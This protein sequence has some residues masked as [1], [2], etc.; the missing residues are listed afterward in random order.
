MF[1]SPSKKETEAIFHFLFTSLSSQQSKEE[2]KFA[3]WPTFDLMNK[4]LLADHGQV[5]E[6][7][8]HESSNIVVDATR[9]GCQCSMH[10]NVARK[11][12]TAISPKFQMLCHHNT[13]FPSLFQLTKFRLQILH[14]ACCT[15]VFH[16]QKADA[17]RL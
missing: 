5:T 8:L 16:S 14:P 15:V 17:F 13:V 9:E 2:F 11:I 6:W 10:H 7:S 3:E 4:V 12:Q 1:M